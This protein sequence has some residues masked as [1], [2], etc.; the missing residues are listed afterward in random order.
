VADGFTKALPSRQLEEFKHNLNLRWLWLRRGVNVQDIVLSRYRGSDESGQKFRYCRAAV[1]LYLWWSDRN[2][3]I[4]INPCFPLSVV[5]FLV[6]SYAVIGPYI[7][8]RNRW[9]SPSFPQHLLSDHSYH[10]SPS[11]MPALRKLYLKKWVDC[12]ESQIN[13]QEHL[14]HTWYLFHV[15]P[16]AQSVSMC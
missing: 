8:T 11:D 3:K 7:L 5:T 12:K 1:Q 9:K 15:M 14:F 16:K 6:S 4:K 13:W 10:S 2:Y